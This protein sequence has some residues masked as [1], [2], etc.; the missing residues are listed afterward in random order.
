MRCTLLSIAICAALGCHAADPIEGQWQVCDGGPILSFNPS[1][2]TPGVLDIV[3]IDGA[4][5]SIPAGTVL[6]TAVATPTPGLYDCTAWTDPRGKRTRKRGKVTFTIKLE[7]KLADTFVFEGYERG[8]KFQL[9]KLLP[10]WYRRPI[11]QVDTRPKG[12]DGAR[13]IDA[14]EAYLEL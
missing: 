1:A 12:L 14:P 3:W 7:S 2:D 6:G 13:R 9:S 5:M 10:F 8:T 4:D 11:K